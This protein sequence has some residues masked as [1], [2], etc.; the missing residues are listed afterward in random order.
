M[1]QETRAT[2]KAGWVAN[3]TD[4][5]A[6]TAAEVRAELDDIADSC[7]NT[8]T[9]ATS[10]FASNTHTITSTSANALAVGPNGA[11]NPTL[12]VACSTASAANGVSITS[13]AAGGNVTIATTSSA[14]NEGLIISSLGT[15]NIVLRPT[16][17]GGIYLQT[18]GANTR[19]SV[20]PS[21][22]TMSP[23]LASS[24]SAAKV[25]FTAPA[26]TG[27]TA[28][29]NVPV[30]N[31]DMSSTRQ[32]S[33]GALTL[34]QDF[35]IT[36]GTHSFVG[37]STV[38]DIATVSISGPPIA[39]TNATF[40]NA[41]ALHIPTRVLTGTIGSASALTIAA[42]S[43]ATD[44]YAMLATGR[45]QNTITDTTTSVASVAALTSPFYAGLT[46]A[47]AANTTAVKFAISGL[48]QHSTNNDITSTGHMGGVL[49]YAQKTGTGTDALVLGVEGRVGAVAGVVTIG[50][51]VVGTFDTNAENAG[52]MDYAAAFYVPT[53]SD[54]GHITNKFAFW[55]NNADW[56]VRSNGPIV[57]ASS[58]TGDQQVIPRDRG[59]VATNAYY[60]IAGVTGLFAST[61]HGR[62]LA[63]AVPFICP[64]KTTWT[65]A[66]FTNGIGVASAVGRMGVYQ[67]SAG[68]PGAR[69]ADFGTVTAGVADTGAREITISQQ[70]EAG[71]YWLV[72]AIQGGASDN[73]ITYASV[74]AWETMGMTAATAQDGCCYVAAAGALPDPF[75]SPTVTGGGFAPF[76]WLRKV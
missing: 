57:L 26:D 66:G 47:P 73:S 49:G 40:V 24:G 76:M 48:A 54:A 12:N 7:W 62:N 25:T 9:D 17:A 15:G 14:G 5:G 46:W 6:N 41:H 20:T 55:N 45:I 31:W 19:F 8:L 38:T 71:V 11:T 74:N 61:S 35:L 70:L 75:G 2:L 33:T 28:S 29:T 22:I 13:T 3:L 68:R 10:V 18:S 59:A 21:T 30:V 67:D 53:Q 56:Q 16:G 32:H 39:G 4:G 60:P 63:W 51:A 72:I 43:G 52:T 58:T 42:P 64:E 1:T 50:A 34:Q 36:G 65:R 69:I 27:Q 23:V 44:N 37:S